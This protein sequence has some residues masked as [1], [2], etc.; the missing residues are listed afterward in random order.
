MEFRPK[1][2]NQKNMQPVA[3]LYSPGRIGDVDL[4]V[5]TY[6]EG[7]LSSVLGK[8]LCIQFFN[9]HWRVQKAPLPFELKSVHVD[10]NPEKACVAGVVDKNRNTIGQVSD[11]DNATIIQNMMGPKVLNADEQEEI[12]FEV[13][14]ETH[15]TM[16]GELFLNGRRGMLKC[17]KEHTEAATKVLCPISQDRFGMLPYRAL[18]G[19]L[20]VQDVVEVEATVPHDMMEKL[21]GMGGAAQ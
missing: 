5:Y 3:M 15:S 14:R 18:N 4:K 20:R 11:S 12:V 8:N 9:F 19:F 16:E 10:L 1:R 17:T 2:I 6:A 21:R 13:T 7:L